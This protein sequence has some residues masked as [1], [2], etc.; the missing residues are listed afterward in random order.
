[1]Y[2]RPTQL[3]D[4]SPDAD[5]RTPGVLTD[6]D[7]LYGT[8]KGLRTL[9]SFESTGATL[10]G[11]SL[12]AYTAVL[13]SGDR[14]VIAGTVDHLY[15]LVAGAWVEFDS[16]QT[17]R[18]ERWRFA[19]FA[20]D[21]L[22]VN[23]VD[24]P[25]VSREGAPFVALALLSD[26]PPLGPPPAPTVAALVEVVD[27]GVFFVPPNS[28]QWAFSQS[29][30]IWTPDI[31]TET[32]NTF[33]PG[34][35]LTGTPGPITAMHRIRGGIVM[36]K[37]ESMYMGVFTGP[38]FFW[39]FTSISENVGVAGNECV[40]NAGDLH[41]FISQ[42]DFYQF[43]GSSL[44]RIPNQVKEWFF[45]RSGFD[46]SG[47]VDINHMDLIEGRWERTK[48]LAVWHYPTIQADPAGSLDNALIYNARVGKW[49]KGPP[50]DSQGNVIT[51]QT[52]VSP[53]FEV[54]V[55]VT[56]EQFGEMFATY[57][58]IPNIQYDSPLFGRNVTEVGGLI[59]STG[60]LVVGTGPPTGGSLTTGEIGDGTAFLQLNRVRPI[61]AVWPVDNQAKLQSYKRRI[62]GYPI[63][64]P[65][66]FPQPGFGPTTWLDKH[67][68][69]NLIITARAHTL[70]IDLFADAE[71]TALA[72]DYMQVG[73][74]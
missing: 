28:N 69:F 29:D 72:L 42:D 33:R 11:P 46:H 55:D 37:A 21:I 48:S 58:D 63:P 16:G 74:E 6:C 19:T 65:N 4:F 54:T 57:N 14:I 44:Q 39:N 62:N 61:F 52:I 20:N 43:D 22:A 24:P 32:V 73:L 17:Y 59:D 25:Q 15:R 13:V 41:L 35:G 18:A 5:P 68:N 26:V 51:V 27:E 38:P 64:D 53:N 47:Q 50:R 30:T 23:G 31:A 7:G 36:Y 56:Y 71:I 40:I 45:G 34:A 9:P 70:Q 60:T 1:M 67:G 12:G 66:P 2:A 49:T 3:G 8:A 10:P